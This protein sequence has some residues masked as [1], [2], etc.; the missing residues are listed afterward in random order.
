M[1]TM[2]SRR[3]IVEDGSLT[4][5]LVELTLERITLYDEINQHQEINFL[6]HAK[7]KP[8]VRGVKCRGDRGH[9]LVEAFSDVA[10]QKGGLNTR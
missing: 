2:Q 3:L 8:F 1:T 7:Q 5:A 4:T 6:L 9:K 10:H